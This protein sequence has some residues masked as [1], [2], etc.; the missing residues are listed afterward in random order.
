VDR[1]A[2]LTVGLGFMMEN[3]VENTARKNAKANFLL[4]DSPL[5]DAKGAPFTLPNVR[6][7]TFREEQ[8][9]FLVGALAG[10][11]TKTNTIGFVGG[12]EI[13]LIKRFE[14]G[15][16]AGV[17]ATNP[18]AKV[19]SNYTGN[20]DDV[21]SGKQVSQDMMAKNV[22]VVF[23]AAGIGGLG[24]FQAVKEAR[25]AGKSVYAIGGD[26]DQFHVAPEVVLTSM[27]KRVDLAVYEADRDV[28]N[29]TFKGGDVVVGLKEGGVGYAEIR[30]NIPNKAEAIQKVEALR[31]KVIAGEIK[32][33]ANME[34]LK[35]FKP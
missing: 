13:P 29:G 24:M 19:L 25:A 27:L 22:D 4:I 6:T 1:G 35:A 5:L 31:R 18:K 33:P 11:V 16:R 3:A 10:L 8:P 28:V 9:S 2:K 23:H 17:M 14:A 32:V 26:Q 21:Q 12:M 15:F 7:V 20:F 30:L 34:E